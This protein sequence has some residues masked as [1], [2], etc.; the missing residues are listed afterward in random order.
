[1]LRDST[2]VAY[3]AAA[4]VFV[5]IAVLTWLRRAH[6][7]TVALSMVAVMMGLGLSSLADAVAVAS[8]TQRAAAVASLAILPL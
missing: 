1:M 5:W 6:N 2:S 3:V 7:P 4:V 8:T